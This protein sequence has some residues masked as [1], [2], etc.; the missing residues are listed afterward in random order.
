M[1]NIHGILL[2]I[3]SMAAFTMEDLFI[4]KLSAGLSTSQIMLVLG[5][6][7]TLIFALMAKRA[8]ENIFARKA[9]TRITVIRAIAEGFSALSFMTSLAL[10]P[11]STVAAG[12]S[13]NTTGDHNGGG[14]VHE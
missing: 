11:I 1:N 4:K 2:V 8:G 14:P 5:F 13:G 10:V 12:F 7:G 6:F 9:W 3:A